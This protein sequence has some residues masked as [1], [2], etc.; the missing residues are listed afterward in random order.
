VYSEDLEDLHH[1]WG[2]RGGCS[3]APAAGRGGGGRGGGVA[4]AR[5]RSSAARDRR[6]RPRGVV[7]GRLA[8]PRHR[9]RPPRAASALPSPDATVRE[10]GMGSHR[11]GGVGAKIR[12]ASCSA[13][14]RPTVAPTRAGRGAGSRGGMS[15]RGAEEGVGLPPLL[16]VGAEERERG[17]CRCSLTVERCPPPPSAPRAHRPTT[18]R[19]PRRRELLR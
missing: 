18:P 6:W 17:S 4:I 16:V 2:P 1:R 5:M 12:P 14:L 9:W 7:A 15:G 19:D 11:Q 8:L 3:S 13:P 10:A